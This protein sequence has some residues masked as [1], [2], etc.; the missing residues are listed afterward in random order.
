MSDS[1]RVFKYPECI[2]VAI[3]EGI[4]NQHFLSW[5]NCQEMYQQGRK[6]SQLDTAYVLSIMNTVLAHH[7]LIGIELGEGV[8]KG[9]A[10]V[11]RELV[12]LR[13][14]F[15]NNEQRLYVYDSFMRSLRDLRS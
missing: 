4:K 1:L 15:I 11:D 8:D 5:I 2:Q 14:Q 3:F 7:T 6:G 12:K 10:R 9:Q 13:K